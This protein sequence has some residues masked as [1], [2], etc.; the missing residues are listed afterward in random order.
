MADAFHAALKEFERVVSEIGETRER[1]QA[2]ENQ[3]DQLR[4]QVRALAGNTDATASAAV[5]SGDRVQTLSI[6]EIVRVVRDLGG[7]ARLAQITKASGLDAKVVA[8]RVQR[9]VQTNALVRSGHG[10]YQ[11][12]ADMLAALASGNA[13]VST[14]PTTTTEE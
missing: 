3:R 8:T 1:L 4:K 2:L 12:P 10:Y 14:A 9:A 6:M 7:S 13:S 11:L 5:S